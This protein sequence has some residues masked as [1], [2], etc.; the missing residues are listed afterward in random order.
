M[1]PS[2][3]GVDAIAS[4]RDRSGLGRADLTG[5][6]RLLGAA[7]RFSAPLLHRHLECLFSYGR[8]RQA[9]TIFIDDIAHAPTALERTVSRVRTVLPRGGAW[10]VCKLGG[11]GVAS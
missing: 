7:F 11:P 10:Y 1:A 3:S 8:W 6:R 9:S 2:E 5:T 4:D